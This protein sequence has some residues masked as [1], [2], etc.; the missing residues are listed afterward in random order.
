MPIL[1]KKINKQHFEIFKK[2]N[3]YVPFSQVAG[4]ILEKVK[5]AAVTDRRKLQKT[6]PTQQ[7]LF[8]IDTRRI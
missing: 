7:C 3:S 5:R 2:Y 1:V 6:R 4:N 8:K